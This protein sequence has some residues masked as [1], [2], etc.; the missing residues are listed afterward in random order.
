MSR[1]PRGGS[2]A[3]KPGT[4]GRRLPPAPIALTVRNIEHQRA[5][6]GIVG[7]HNVRA[8]CMLR[9]A[10]KQLTPVPRPA[11]RRGCPWAAATLQ[12]GE[13]PDRDPEAEPPDRELGGIEQ[14]VGTGER[15]ADVRAD[16]ERAN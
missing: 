11:V 5:V 16:G 12:R 1:A 2:A 8:N 4:Y 9:S 10:P 14:G 6:M 15:H 13:A 3:A 7:W